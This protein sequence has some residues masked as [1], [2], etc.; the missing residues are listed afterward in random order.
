MIAFLTCGTVAANA[1]WGVVRAAKL[2]DSIRTKHHLL[3]EANDSAAVLETVVLARI[4][5]ADTSTLE[6]LRTKFASRDPKP[7]VRAGRESLKVLNDSKII[8]S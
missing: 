2:A 3:D 4:M 6:R 8:Y 5:R 1:V 7:G